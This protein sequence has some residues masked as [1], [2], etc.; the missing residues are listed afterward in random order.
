MQL[1]ANLRY[2]IYMS[3]SDKLNSFFLQQKFLFDYPIEN[4]AIEDIELSQG[5]NIKP[6]CRFNFQILRNADIVN[7][8]SLIIKN[9]N[10][11]V[12]QISS[13][14]EN[15]EV[16]IGGKLIEKITGKEIYQFNK[17][18]KQD[19]N[20]LHID[21][22]FWFRNKSTPLYLI[23][24]YE[25]D[26]RFFVEYS[27]NSPVIPIENFQW[28]IEYVYMDSWERRFI[29][30]NPIL[31]LI[32]SEYDNK[33]TYYLFQTQKDG[34]T[35]KYIENNYSSISSLDYDIMQ[36]IEEYIGKTRIKIFYYYGGGHKYSPRCGKIYPKKKLKNIKYHLDP[37]ENIIPNLQK[38]IPGEKKYIKINK[39]CQFG[40]KIEYEMNF[41]NIVFINKI[42]IELTLPE[43]K[44]LENAEY[45]IIKTVKL[46][47]DKNI[48]FFHKDNHRMHHLLTNDENDCINHHLLTN[49]FI[50]IWNNIT[51]NKSYKNNKTSQVG[52][53]TC[54]FNLP[55]FIDDHS[56]PFPFRK[57]RLVFEFEELENLTIDKNNKILDFECQVILRHINN[58]KSITN[59]EVGCNF[60]SFKPCIKEKLTSHEQAFTF[61]D[62]ESDGLNREL[63]W[64]FED[65]N[66]QNKLFNY[67]SVMRDGSVVL[68]GD[69]RFQRQDGEYFTITQQN[70]FHSSSVDNV[71]MYSYVAYPENSISQH[72]LYSHHVDHY[73]FKFRIKPNINPNN[74]IIKI[75]H[76]NH[77]VYCYNV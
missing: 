56:D 14:I 32:P 59:S 73:K 52:Y 3:R 70:K 40:N 63:F 42:D 62:Q 9:Q 28:I 57:F 75:F 53:F 2:G 18:K 66:K 8:I 15:V 54:K 50:Y 5:G 64:I 12:D 19:P 55:F 76:V 47:N 34:I 60:I 68:N 30:Q 22:P 67:E 69:D 37:F 10:L 36:D 27:N 31:H 43:L 61:S 23:S 4:Y 24:L 7:N 6:G 38:N 20:Y 26:V 74:Y 17:L 1:V 44:F 29:A 51:G 11:N 65:P 33:N 39:K 48:V 58:N 35:Y 41:D 46:Y 72:G 21:I 25:I 45:G 13:I 16:Q 77:Q 71:Y 49:D